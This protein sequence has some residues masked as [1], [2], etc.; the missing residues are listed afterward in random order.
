LPF[1]S[2]HAV[3]CLAL[4]FRLAVCL[5]SNVTPYVVHDSAKSTLAFASFR[6]RLNSRSFA[7]CAAFISEA[8]SCSIADP[9]LLQI[10]EGVLTIGTS[11]TAA[12]CHSNSTL[13]CEFLFVFPFFKLIPCLRGFRHDPKRLA[14]SSQL[15]STL[16]NLALNQSIMDRVS[17][18]A[19]AAKKK[20]IE[21][22]C[23][24]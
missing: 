4:L 9:V 16:I 15:N 13:R 5:L 3:L 20:V 10:N 11:F 7:L 24:V 21:S 14:D 6:L 22:A 12:Q 23:V 8:F 17:A 18:G 19:D 1:C 2:M